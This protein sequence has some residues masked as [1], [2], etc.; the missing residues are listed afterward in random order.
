MLVATLLALCAPQF[1]D[2]DAEAL[3]RFDALPLLRQAMV[4]RRVEQ[5][6]REMQDEPA[7]ARIANLHEA[8][9]DLP[10]RGPRPHFDPDEWTGGVAVARVVIPPTDPRHVAVRAAAPRVDVLADLH[11][12]VAYDWAK[13]T[14]VKEPKAP[15]FRE[16]FENLLHGYAPGTDHAFAKVQAALDWDA[17]QA[18]LRAYFE[19]AYADLDGGVYEGVTIYEAWYGGNTLNMPD[20][21]VIPFAVQ[22]L[23]DRSYRSPIPADARRTRLYAQ[24]RD[25]ALAY[26]QYKTTIEAGAAAF[27]CADPQMDEMYARMVPRF[28]Y[29]WKTHGDDVARV[30]GALTALRTRDRLIAE[31]DNTVV[32][33][34]EAMAR[35]DGR[36]R[37][38]ATMATRVREAALTALR[39]EKSAP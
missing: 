5:R 22:V 25:K 23:G 21:D 3:R 28:H 7:L 37:E 13:G 6:L 39:E 35:R 26:R 19:H 27:V 11:R 31:V 38:L 8:E 12:H 18:P 33:D 29:L 16:R 15:S 2:S 20:V 1:Q 9:E 34:P 17:R 32:S 14:L 4:V 24:I 10:V 30:H 36:K